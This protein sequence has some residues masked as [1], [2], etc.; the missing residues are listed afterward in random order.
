MPWSLRITDANGRTI[1][2]DLSAKTRTKAWH[3]YTEACPHDPGP[4]R[5]VELLNGGDVV[6]V[7]EWKLV[8]TP[9]AYR[10]RGT[11][12]PSRAGNPPK[13]G[14]GAALCGE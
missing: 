12:R 13:V 10:M 6:N 4:L 5:M 3:A 1:T 11:P 8:G 2:R 14:Y 9:D 7:T